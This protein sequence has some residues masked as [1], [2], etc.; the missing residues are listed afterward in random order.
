MTVMDESPKKES[1]PE[2]PD[3]EIL[4]DFTLIERE[5]IH[6]AFEKLQSEEPLNIVETVMIREYEVKLQAK[7]DREELMRIP[8][9]DDV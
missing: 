2:L 3:L 5:V 9:D 6:N 1:P 7:K 8:K 4:M